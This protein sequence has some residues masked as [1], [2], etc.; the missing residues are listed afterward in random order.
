MTAANGDA[1]VVYPLRDVL[2]RIDG[3]IDKVEIRTTDGLDS[4]ARQLADGLDRAA[5]ERCAAE[6]RLDDRL[7]QIES[8]TATHEAVQT[9]AGRARAAVLVSAGA[10]LTGGASFVAILGFVHH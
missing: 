6:T 8:S 2:D 4:L 5:A 3:R 9:A 1:V 10:V 7:Q